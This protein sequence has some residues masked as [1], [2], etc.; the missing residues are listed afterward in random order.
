MSKQYL[1]SDITHSSLQPTSE[2]TEV[3]SVWIFKWQ[4]DW[5]WEKAQAVA[6]SPYI[7]ITKCTCS[8]ECKGDL[9]WAGTGKP[10]LCLQCLILCT[11]IIYLNQLGGHM[12][13]GFRTT[14][15]AAGAPFQSGVQATPIAA[16]KGQL[17]LPCKRDSCR[18]K[19]WM[20]GPLLPWKTIAFSSSPVADVSLSIL[21][22]GGI[23]TRAFLHG[24]N[25]LPRATSQTKSL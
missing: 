19:G 13:T 2:D 5:R 25:L 12:E 16:K 18:P 10:Y 20:D 24:L 7:Q 17:Q 14:S 23:V 9:I 1:A 4:A 3:P 11:L 6:V 21:E 8:Q 22:M 15:L